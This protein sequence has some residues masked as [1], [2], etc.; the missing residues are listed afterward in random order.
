MTYLTNSVIATAVNRFGRTWGSFAANL[1]LLMNDVASAIEGEGTA[2]IAV[3]GIRIA[4]PAEDAETVTIGAD[5]YEFDTDDTYTD[6]NIQ[7]DLTGG[8][9]VAAA[10]TLGMATQ[11]TAGDTITIGDEVYT[12]VP[13]GTALSD[14]EVDIGAN[15]GEAQVNLVA[16][17]NGTDSVSTA[18]AF[19][20][21]GDFG[22]DTMLATAIT[23]GTAGDDIAEE[24]TFT[25]GTD[26]WDADIGATTAGVDATA[27]EA[28]DVLIEV[29]NASATEDVVAIEISDYEILIMAGTAGADVTAMSETM[30]GAG[31][32][33]NAAALTNGAAVAHPNSLVQTRVPTTSEAALGNIHIPLPFTPS[34]T[35]VQVRTTSTGAAIAWD[36]DVIVTAGDNPYLTVNND[37]SV[38]FAATDTVSV[39][40]AA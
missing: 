19:V 24:E 29:I 28:S 22:G 13:L 33:V 36:G 30:S 23:P 37:G 16:A 34:V 27:A 8:S 25:D 4:V 40:L 15:I 6:G 1:T 11:P 12:F 20:T 7:V 31:N 9:E 39:F 14:H 3:G 21:V 35:I 26:A 5:V 18:S 38:D 2:A 10:G 32:A 17:I